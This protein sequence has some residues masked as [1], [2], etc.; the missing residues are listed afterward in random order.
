MYNCFFTC[1]SDFCCLFVV[2]VDG[3]GG[4]VF[5]D[6]GEGSGAWDLVGVLVSMW[7]GVGREDRKGEWEWDEKAR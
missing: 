1:F 7:R 3:R 5:L 4:V 2:E 6:A